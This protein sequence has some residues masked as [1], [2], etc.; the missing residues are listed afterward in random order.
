MKNKDLYR[1]T[2]SRLQSSS[3]IRWE[4]YRMRKRDH[5]GG[6]PDQPP[7]L[8]PV[9]TRLIT[10]AAVI[11]LL[12]VIGGIAVAV[13]FL[14][15]RDLLIPSGSRISAIGGSV[16]S[17]SGLADS[18]EGRALD[19]WES[20]LAEYDSDRA[21]LDR[22]GNTL[23]PALADYNCYLVYTREMADKL[24]EIAARHGLKLHTAQADLNAHPELLPPFWAESV[25][26]YPTYIY[27][28]G[29]FFMDADTYIEGAGNTTFQLQRSVRGT[30]H[31]V[32]ICVED[33]S[34]FTSW[35]YR[36]AC[37]VPVAL[38]LG[39]D[40]AFLLADLGDS[41][42]T[43]AVLA[44]SD[45]GLTRTGLESLA[46]RLDLTRL[47]PAVPPVL[48]TEGPAQSPAAERTSAREVYAAALRDWLYSGVLPDGTAGP[49]ITGGE[50]DQFAVYDVDGDGAEEL[51]VLFTDTYT[52][53]QQGLVLS[54]DG[55]YTGYGSPVFTELDGFPMFTFYSGGFAAVGASHNQ[56]YGEL[57]PYTLYRY[58]PESGRYAELA[59]VYSV[60]LSILEQTGRAEEYPAGADGTGAG[61]VYYVTLTYASGAEPAGR[62]TM[63]SA[64]YQAWLADVMGGEPAPLEV[65]YLSLTEENIASILP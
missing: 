54:F 36:A 9:L 59:S 23:D 62:R 32:F 20:F 30:L 17:L 56:T 21:I 55:T 16:I 2:F 52:A 48:P 60:S 63:D 31:D 22:V 28:D 29:T 40:R 6:Y 37:G 53:A 15:L 50:Y 19:E 10:A 57:W 24:E 65:P 5:C 44:G 18:P 41:V 35:N 64:Q 27:E 1:E 11:C 4:D 25:S 3:D 47:T 45:H 43:A 38:A 12:A 58:D 42:V 39:G 13:N 26:A 49:E 46:D 14:G 51:V 33:V 8:R 61:S 34:R 7:R